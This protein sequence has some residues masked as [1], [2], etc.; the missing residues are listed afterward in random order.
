MKFKK[1]YR[2]THSKT[3]KITQE[4][5]QA[6]LEKSLR[7]HPELRGGLTPELEEMA[8]MKISYETGQK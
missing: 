8:K 4:M 6:A 3:M 7:E 1:K 5:W 2:Y